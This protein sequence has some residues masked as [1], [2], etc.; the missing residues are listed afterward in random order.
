M[1]VLFERGLAARLRLGPFERKRRATKPDHRRRGERDAQAEDQPDRPEAFHAGLSGGEH[2][3][4][5]ADRQHD[6]R[7]CLVVVEL[8][9]KP[10][11]VHVDRPGRDPGRVQAPDP[12]QQL[13]ARDGPAGMAGEVVEQLP[14]ALRELA[15]LAVIEANLVPLEVGLAAL[16]RKSPA[17]PAAAPAPASRRPRSGRAAP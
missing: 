2:V 9:A 17:R 7:A 11:D 10:R 5:A 4:L 14:L 12:C 16:E 6:S 13:V 1:Q 15:P 3:A 8:L